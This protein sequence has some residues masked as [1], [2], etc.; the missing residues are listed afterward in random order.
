MSASARVLDALRRTR[1]PMRFVGASG[2]LGYGVPTPAFDAALARQPDLIGADMGSI[3]IGPTYLGK[4]EMATAPAATRRDLR[5]LLHGAREKDIPLVIGSAGSAGAAPHLDATLAI[6]REIARADGLHFRLGVLRAD[7][8]RPMLARAV[9]DGRVRGIDDMPA[10]TEEEVTEAAQI[11]GQMGM[12]P[13]RRALAEDVDVIIA[14]RA[15][16]TAIFAALPTMLG[17]SAGLAVHMAKIIECASLCCVPGG[18]DAILAELDDEGFVLESMN[19]Q[20]RA[21]PTSVAAHSLYEQS[22]PFTVYEPEGKLDLAAAQYVAV[23]DRRTRVTGAEW[24]AST[25]PCVKIEGARKIGE[26]AVLLAGAADPRFIAQ[27]REIL[28]AVSDVVRDLVCED[29][30]QDYTLRFRVYGVDGVR[31]AAPE[32]EPPPGEVFV[33]GECIAPTAER[34]SEVVRTCKQYLLHHGYPGRLSTA[35]NLAFP[36]TPP[37]VSLGPA[38]RFS[39]YHLLHTPDPDALFPLEVEAL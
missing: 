20:R 39:V 6:V 17:F 14:G 29:T 10:L 11:V 22:D 35:G 24:E 23:D 27:H 30:P 34:A 8:S 25:D 7:L 36:F 12:G 4:G 16:D 37:E 18:R 3:D 15:C 9:R 26:R 32:H 33:M 5:K 1:R 19:P 13:F 2:Q 21:T 38:Y 31:M 28:A